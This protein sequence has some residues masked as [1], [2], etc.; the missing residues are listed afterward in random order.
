MASAMAAVASP[1]EGW[2]KLCRGCYLSA[3]WSPPAVTDEIG[4]AMRDALRL[5][6]TLPLASVHL[7][8]KQYA[9]E[10][11]A[12]ALDA[13]EADKTGR[14]RK[15]AAAMRSVAVATSPNFKDVLRAKVL[16]SGE[17]Y[18]RLLH[19]YQRLVREHVLPRL[20]AAL[21]EQEFAVQREPSIRFSL[22]DASALGARENDEDACIGLHTDGDYDHQPGELN[23]MLALSR[24]FGSNG[25]FVESEPM[26]GDYHCVELEAG[27]LFTFHG[28]ACR[29]Y[30]QRNDTGCTRVSIDFRLIPMSRYDHS[31]DDVSRKASRAGRFTLGEYF[32]LV[33]A[34]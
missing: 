8:R 4:E 17:P 7:L 19:A 6:P 3:D 12:A 15:L 31:R 2:A 13:P 1:Q 11:C 23:V 27:R 28:V 10:A 29:H 9:R 25:L 30:N 5:D 26:R 34:D 14:Q 32:E 20:A 22:P 21:G 16:S 33:R 24:V 18:A